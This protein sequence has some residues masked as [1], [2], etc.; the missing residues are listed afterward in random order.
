MES[1]RVGMVTSYSMSTAESRRD[2]LLDDLRDRVGDVVDV[3]GGESGDADAAGVDGVDR[4]FLAQAPYLL[5]AEAGVGEHAALAQHEAEVRRRYAFLDL[6]DQQLA[7]RLHAVAHNAQLAVPQA[8][9]IRRTEHGCHDLA[10]VRWRVGVVGAH[11]A[12][13]LRKDPRRFLGARGDDA[14]RT[15]PLAVQRERLGKRAGEE[16]RTGGLGEEARGI[17]VGF[18]ALGEAL[19]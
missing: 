11:D 14:E 13:Q 3:A 19:V 16:Y 8:S 17:A 18:Q 10:A 5:L 4:V 12:L 9:E 15:H 7:H 1:A 2:S 6:L